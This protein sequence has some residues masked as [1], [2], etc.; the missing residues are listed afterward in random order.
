MQATCGGKK[1]H[2]TIYTK[3][4][5]EQEKIDALYKYF[6]FK[7][8]FCKLEGNRFIGFFNETDYKS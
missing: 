3:Y 6:Y 2:W 5:T 7:H 4:F 8:L 1:K